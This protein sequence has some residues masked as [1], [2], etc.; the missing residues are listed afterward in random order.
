MI[1]VIIGFT[2]GILTAILYYE[3]SSLLLNTQR[4]IDT[5]ISE[6]VPNIRESLAAL[7]E[8]GI[9]IDFQD[10]VPS[11]RSFSE[12]LLDDKT[13]KSSS[14]SHYYVQVGAFSKQ[15]DGEQLKANLLLK[16]FLSQHIFVESDDAKNLY[17]V[18]IG[19]YTEK[20][21]AIMSLSWAHKQ[22]FEGLVVQRPKT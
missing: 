3:S 8:A 18:L 14:N 7:S 9:S 16:G 21:K 19:P 10:I 17:R 15:T 4:V 13:T 20:G 11:I 12:D 1:R 22:E 2:I 5:K 6:Q